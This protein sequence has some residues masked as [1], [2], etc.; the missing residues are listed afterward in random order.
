MKINVLII[1]LASV[2]AAADP[3]PPAE[4]T[5]PVVDFSAPSS[6]ASQ[7]L[8]FSA[9]LISATGQ[10]MSGSLLLK[11]DSIG[12]DI[13]KNGSVE[14]R[15]IEIL[16]IKRIDFIEWKGKSLGNNGFVFYPSR[17]RFTLQDGESHVCDH[18]IGVLNRMLFKDSGGT[19]AVYTYF[20]D[21]RKQGVWENSGRPEIDYP[22]NNPLEDTIVT[23]IFDR[24]AG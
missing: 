14:K 8:V 2:M 16:R 4:P 3:R 5:D 22:E 17:T 23:I 15:K 21:Y 20:Y 18:D 13:G 1:I 6:T 7:F 19:R 11:F 12:I 24:N 10:R 9:S